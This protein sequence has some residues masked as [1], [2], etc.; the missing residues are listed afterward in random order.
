MG[1]KADYFSADEQTLVVSVPTQRNAT[2]YASFGD[3]FAYFSAAGM[4]VLAGAAFHP[5][6]HRQNR[7]TQK[8]ELMDEPTTVISDL[9]PARP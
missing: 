1:H 6:R 9:Q 8:D 4:L 2:V 5:K 3:T 7:E